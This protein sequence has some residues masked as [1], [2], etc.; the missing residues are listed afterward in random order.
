M[1]IFG[2]VKFKTNCGGT[3]MEVNKFMEYFKEL[4]AV[5]IPENQAELHAL[6]YAELKD[7]ADDIKMLETKFK[8]LDKIKGL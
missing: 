2:I 6:M 3:I 4:R 1:Y 5:G 7:L 8:I